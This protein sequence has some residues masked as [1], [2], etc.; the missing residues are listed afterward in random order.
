MNNLL[1][2]FFVG[3]LLTGMGTTFAQNS[4]SVRAT[5]VDSLKLIK[6][7]QELVYHNTSSDTLESIYLTDWINAFSSKETPLAKRFSEEYY[8]KFHFAKQEEW[9][10]T[11]IRKIINEDSVNLKWTRPKGAPDLIRI[12]LDTL[13]LPG[14]QYELKINYNL[15]IPN[16]EF[17]G[18]GY[19]SNGNYK[20]RYWFLVPGVYEETWQVYSHK[21]LNDRYNPLLKVE[22]FLDIPDYLAPIS[23][24]KTRRID[25]ETREGRKLVYLSGENRLE[26]KLYLTRNYLFD[27]IDTEHFNVITNIDDEGLSPPLKSLFV[28][29]IVE[30]LDNR[31][32]NYPHDLMLVTQEDYSSNPFYG[33]NQLPKFIRPFPDGF[34]YDLKQLKTITG[35]YLENSLLLNQREEKWVFD[36]IQVYLMMEYINEFYP[37]MKLLGTLS[38]VIGIRWFHAADLKFNDQYSFFYMHMARSDLDQALTTSKDSLVKF[39]RLIASAYKAGIGMEYLDNFLQDSTVSR[40]IKEFYTS[41]LLE[42]TGEQ[43]FN[44]ILVENAH[45]NIEWFFDDYVA[46]DEIID[47]KIT[48]V[49]KDNDSLLVTIKNKTKNGMPVSLYGLHKQEIVFKTWVEQVHDKKTISIP[50]RNITRVALNYEGVIPEINQRDNYRGVGILLDKPLQIRLFKDVEDPRYTQLFFMPEVQ[51]NLYDGVSFGPKLYNQ[52][53][54]KKNFEYQITPM[55]GTKSQTIVGGAG[56]SHVIRFDNQNLY[57]M[58]FG[59]SASRFSYGYNLFYEKFTPS[60]SMAFRESNLREN[61]RQYLTVRNVNVY[62]DQSLL[63]PLDVPDYSVFN[64]NY[65][66]SNPGMVD[67][68]TG[69]VDFQLSGLF[70]KFSVT[71]EYRKL[72]KNNRQINLRFFAGAFLYNDLLDSNYFSFALDRPTDYLYDYNYYGRSETSGLFSQQIIMAEGG[73]KSQLQ[74]EFANQWLTTFNGSTNLWK[75]IYVYGDLGFMKN[76]NRKA[77]FVY[78]SG[79]RLSFIA[80]YFEV[81][82]PVY[83]NLGWEINQKDYDQKIRFIATLDLRTLFSLFSREW[84]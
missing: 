72:F 50:K 24:L 83:S 12:Q 26:T 7:D 43:E 13:L 55:Y 3:L 67:H 45:K 8:R 21:N 61:K 9:G 29:R 59:A 41:S 32:G 75:W 19:A 79:I 68:F 34:N 38:D 49:E 11:N 36:A 5:L 74:P 17:T 80:D 31:L 33:L 23:D 48:N 76:R 56:F 37:D 53:L 15:K 62:R 70:S 57:A 64:I 1:N 35:N 14:Q 78:D 66:Y 46:T 58:S 47:F 63:R 73:F 77:K 25:T 51:F 16:E 52:T 82:F 28:N 60:F 2:R 65:R 4:V 6:I 54:L 10:Y 30:F 84:Y 27:D 44:Q 40:S 81:F 18:N 22:I 39:N 20:L 42:R 69:N 71:S